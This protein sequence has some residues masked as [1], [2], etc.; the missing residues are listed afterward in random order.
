MD[1][2]KTPSLP[3]QSPDAGAKQASSQTSVL[4]RAYCRNRAELMLSCYRKNEVNDPEIYVT[5]VITI[6]ADGYTKSVVD[7]VTDPRTGLPSEQTFL[8]S[9]YEI[10]QACNARAQTEYHLAKPSYKSK[11]QP[12]QAQ[13]RQRGQFSYAEFLIWAAENNKSDRPVGAFEHQPPARGPTKPRQTLATSTQLTI[14][15]LTETQKASLVR[16][17]RVEATRDALE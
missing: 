17:S 13:P 6:L 8:P 11:S 4:N 12:Y 14:Q 16:C 2:W 3:L 7:Y 5:S 10:R 15:E 9:I 1:E